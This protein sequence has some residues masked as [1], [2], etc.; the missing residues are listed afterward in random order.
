MKQENARKIGFFSSLA[1]ALGTIIG[2]G[3]FLKNTSVLNAQIDANTN[4]FSFWSMIVSWGLSAIIIFAAA[5]SFAE[6]STSRKS[7]AGLAGW[8]EQLSNKKY[9]RFVRV[10]HPMYYY[11]IFVGVLPFLAVEGLYK[12]IDL[13]INGTSSNGV[14]FGYI[15]L[16]GFIILGSLILINFFST[17]GSTWLQN[18]SMILKIIPIGL[19]L[20]VGLA[21]LNESN[22]LNKTSND[23][24]TS[25]I[26]DLYG[27][28]LTKFHIPTTQ[29][30]NV[31]GMFIALPSIL[32]A[33]DSFTNIGNMSTNLKNPEKTVPL[34]MVISVLTAAVIY[35]LIALGAA[36]TGFGD[37]SSIL[38]TIVPDVAVNADQIR[39]SLDIIINIFITIS[40][41]GVVNGMSFS[42]IRG[43][44]S[45]IDSGQ[46]MGWRKLSYMNQTKNNLGTLLLILLSAGSIHLIVGIVATIINNDAIVDSITNLPTLFFMAIYASIILLGMI[47]R[48]TKKQ[49]KKV[50][51][52]EVVAPIAILGIAV[53]FSYFF[54]YQY[55]YAIAANANLPSSSGLFFNKNNGSLQ[56]MNY[57]DA[58]IFWV[59]LVWFIGFPFL[60]HLVIKKTGGYKVDLTNAVVETK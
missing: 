26:K 45:I 46:I 52:F 40:A 58:I 31:E 29:T 60:N 30:F 9:G 49:C 59:F 20:I 13:S 2:I 12:A 47:D 32:F 17:K 34:I 37:A 5:L 27:P 18:S 33:F 23:L 51:G 1:M 57:D 19:V 39:I 8:A 38:K 41:I 28:D 54:F 15:F 50:F 7:S 48:Y 25:P 3:I 21:N 35:I 53:I 16:G 22:I 55:I 24:L 56:W 10:Q 6:I 11:A 14:H 36:F 42:I 44:Q 43:A 4:T